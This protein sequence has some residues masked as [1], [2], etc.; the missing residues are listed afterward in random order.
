MLRLRVA[1]K[2]ADIDHLA[3]ELEPWVPTAT[4][5]GD[6]VI[7]IRAAG[8]NPSDVKACFGLMPHAVW[9]RTPGRDWAGVVT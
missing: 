6:V 7:E 3:F 1:T 4:D 8:V 9:P 5:A 2:V